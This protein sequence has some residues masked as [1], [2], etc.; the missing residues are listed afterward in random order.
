MK[1]VDQRTSA[2]VAR[3]QVQ[4]RVDR[5]AGRA[6]DVA[7]DNR[8]KRRWAEP[9][10][11]DI[12]LDRQRVERIGIAGDYE[13]LQQ[14]AINAFGSVKQRVAT[15]PGSGLRSAAPRRPPGGTCL[16]AGPRGHGGVSPGSGRACAA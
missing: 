5:E 16:P 15:P 11:F 10:R 3:D 9:D 12:E 14:T 1:E 7:L 6:Q 13:Q 8:D 2:Q 4:I